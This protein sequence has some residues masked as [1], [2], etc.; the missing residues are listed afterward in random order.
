VRISEQRLST[1]AQLGL[2]LLYNGF[3]PF[4]HHAQQYR[5]ARQGRIAAGPGKRQHVRGLRGAPAHPRRSSRRQVLPPSRSKQPQGSSKPQGVEGFGAS[6][7][8]TL[9]FHKSRKRAKS[10]VMQRYEAAVQDK[11]KAARGHCQ[12][13]IKRFRQ[14]TEGANLAWI[15]KVGSRASMAHQPARSASACHGLTRQRMSLDSASDLGQPTVRPLSVT[16][17]STVITA[18]FFQ[19]FQQGIWQR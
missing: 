2:A 11:S 4:T 14:N 9:V 18:G 6:A 16:A 15:F 17:N 3:T 10:R 1:D 13:N 12:A 7:R 19:S 8:V 5:W